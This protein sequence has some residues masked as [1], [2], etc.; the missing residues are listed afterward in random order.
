[1]SSPPRRVKRAS[2]ASVS[3]RGSAA[4][5]ST[6]MRSTQCSWKPGW[7]RKP[8]RGSASRP[9]RSMRGA[10]VARSHA[11]V[12]GLAGHRAHRAE[13]STCA[14]SRRRPRRRSRAATRRAPSGTTASGTASIDAPRQAR[15]R[16]AAERRRQRERHVAPPRRPPRRGRA[17]AIAAHASRDSNALVVE[18]GEVELD[19]LRLDD[20]RR[21]RRHVEAAR[22]RPAACRRRRARSSS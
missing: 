11:R 13:E 22:S 1:M 6:K 8:T 2:T 7:R 19:R 17:R 21:R 9:A 18:R 12:V 4:S 5:T 16:S 10:A 14:A 3:R 20:A 15:A